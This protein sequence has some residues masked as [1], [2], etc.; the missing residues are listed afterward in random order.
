MCAVLQKIHHILITNHLLKEASSCLGSLRNS[1][2]KW[3][4][5]KYNM[6]QFF[7]GK[8]DFAQLFENIT[9]ISIIYLNNLSM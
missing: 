2:Y 7:S 4:A 5:S 8:K 9:F 3:T 1:I 6:K